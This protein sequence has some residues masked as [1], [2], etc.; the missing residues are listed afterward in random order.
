MARGGKLR[1]QDSVMLTIEYQDPETG[2]AMVEEFA[3]P[4]SELQAGRNVAKGRMLI[5]FIDGL[6]VMAT[7]PLPSAWSQARESWADPDAFEMCQQ[8]RQLLAKD[9]VSI[10]DDPEVTR[11]T[12]LWDRYCTRFS[13]PSGG[14]TR[15]ASPEQGWPAARGN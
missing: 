7:R 3:F 15:R 11:V 4:L 8:G 5:D 13:R 12:G 2:D 14:A 6:A 10:K 9:A 1:E